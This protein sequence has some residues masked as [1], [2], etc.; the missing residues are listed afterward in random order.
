S[1]AG[2]VFIDSVNASLKLMTS[3]GSVEALVTSGKIVDGVGN[4]LAV[5]DLGG[6]YVLI[7][8]AP[9][10]PFT[11]TG[12]AGDG[13]FATGANWSEGVAPANNDY[14]HT[15]RFAIGTPGTVTVA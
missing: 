1:N 4:G 14:A 7:T 15:G 6:G 13:L 2:A 11:W 9:V 10:L 8:S 5:D 12:A 3:P